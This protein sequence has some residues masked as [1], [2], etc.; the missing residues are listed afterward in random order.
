MLEYST[1]H[2]MRVTVLPVT[3]CCA[4]APVNSGLIQ[5]P[6][7]SLDQNFTDY[8]SVDAPGLQLQ[9]APQTKMDVTEMCFK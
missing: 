8:I 2:L 4:L 1:K 5:L 7:G 6:S 9:N 3:L